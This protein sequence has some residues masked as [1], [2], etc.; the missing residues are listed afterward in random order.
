[1]QQKL[2]KYQELTYGEKN[3][4]GKNMIQQSMDY[5]LLASNV[6]ILHYMSSSPPSQVTDS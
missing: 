1:M 2:A 5:L 6:R 4:K 3:K